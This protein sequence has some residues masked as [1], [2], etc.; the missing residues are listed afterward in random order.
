MNKHKTIEQLSSSNDINTLYTNFKAELLAAT[1]IESGY[2]ENSIILGRKEVDSNG[3]IREINRIRVKYPSSDPNSPFFSIQT[4]RN[5]IYDTLP[6]GIFHGVLP[7][8]KNVGKEEILYEITTHRNEEFYARRFFSLYEIEI[9]RLRIMFQFNEMIFYKKTIYRDFTNLFLR[10]WDIIDSMNDAEALRFIIVIPYINTI[11]VDDNKIAKAISFILEDDIKI[12]RYNIG[13]HD[14]GVLNKSYLSKMILGVNSVLSVVIDKQPKLKCDVVNLDSD[15][16]SVYLENGRKRKILETLFSICTDSNLN[17][18][19]SISTI[20]TSKF[21]GLGD[22]N[23]YL[24]IN[25][26]LNKL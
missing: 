23:N 4:G 6:E 25:T 22:K 13:Y 2:D 10:H 21:W 5:S 17:Y 7:S 20:E 18:T 19:L 26:H 12:K 15:S 24:G 11:K 14:V 9:D 16:V 3:F 1:L 8:G